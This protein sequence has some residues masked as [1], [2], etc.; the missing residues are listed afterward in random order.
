VH[1]IIHS[2]F[3]YLS[4]NTEKQ[5][6]IE[7]LCDIVVCFICGTNLRKLL[8]EEAYKEAIYSVSLF[9]EV[10]DD[11]LTFIIEVLS[12]N[13]YRIFGCEIEAYL[14]NLEFHELEQNLRFDEPKL[15]VISEAIGC[16][17]DQ[18]K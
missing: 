12:G 6:Y 1:S 14:L 18:I 2:V 11:E 9:F 4:L 8:T 13:P 10:R 16:S 7:A 15:I 3:K 17:L 5:R